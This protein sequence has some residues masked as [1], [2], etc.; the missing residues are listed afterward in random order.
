MQQSFCLFVYG[1]LLQ[2]DVFA[3]ACFW[4]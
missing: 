2:C 3:V 1:L 4:F